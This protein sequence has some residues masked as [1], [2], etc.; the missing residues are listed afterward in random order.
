M[1]GSRT[2]VAP[3]TPTPPGVLTPGP[4]VPNG[5]SLTQALKDA[6]VEVAGLRQLL[7]E[8]NLCP[9]A[10]HQALLKKA[11]APLR[12]IQTRLDSPGLRPASLV[13]SA[14]LGL[15]QQLAGKP[16]SVTPSTLRTAASAVDLLEIL[17]ADGVRSDLADAPKPRFLAVDDDL[18]CRRALGLAL[19]G[20][21]GAASLASSGEEALQLASEQQFD[22]VFLDIEMPEMD[23][24]EVCAALRA[25][26]SHRSVPIVFVTSHTDFADRAKSITSGG[27]DF[28]SKPFLRSELAVKAVTLHL[29]ARLGNP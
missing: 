23:G 16:A 15:V 25:T 4:A 29:K 18:I 10:G 27:N 5:Q 12:S 6:R 9:P 24:F 8:L 14:L 7:R 19:A 26:K 21:F 13:T 28:M 3:S 17:T 1:S 20:P 22:A 2:P 11:L